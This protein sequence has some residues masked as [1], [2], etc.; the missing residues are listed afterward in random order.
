M[1]S[2]TV[3]SE[4]EIESPS[5]LGKKALQA[6]SQALDALALSLNGA[7]DKT[8]NAILKST[9]YLVISG[10][11][12]SELVG[13]K[14]AA[15]FCDIGRPSLFVHPNE[16]LHGN[17]EMIRAHSLVVLISV[18]GESCRLLDLVPSLHQLSNKII[19]IVGERNSTLAKEADIVLAVPYLSETYLKK[20]MPDPFTNI[21]MAI[22]NTIAAAL[23]RMQAF[24][25]VYFMENSSDA[26]PSN[27]LLSK[28][29]D[30]M[31]R[32]AEKD[33]SIIAPIAT[34]RQVIESM[35]QS[36]MGLV[37][38]MDDE[39]LTGIITDSDLQLA[40]R[41]A[42]FSMTESTAADIMHWNPPTI[43]EDA[44]LSDAEEMMNR[45]KLKSLVALDDQSR[46]SGVIEIY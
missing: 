10:T 30:I 19:A 45:Q 46:V 38:V 21:I 35:V 43:S 6:Q 24:K 18:S 3:I 28:V 33:L 8:V 17:S 15:M 20:I 9:D 31:Q 27:P 29:R 39:L 40:M 26:S 25:P 7:F 5:N 13:R 37:L 23:M 32:R 2:S 11:G 16:V 41:N 12:K 44:L 4:E 34:A 22:G 42:S 14:M 36:R 1:D